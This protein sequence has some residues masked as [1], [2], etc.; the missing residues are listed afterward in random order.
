A[1]KIAGA[2]LVAGRGTMFG[3]MALFAMLFYAVTRRLGAPRPPAP[4]V[5]PPV[6]TGIWPCWPH[7]YHDFLGPGGALGAPLPGPGP[8][9]TRARDW[10]WCGAL[11]ALATWTTLSQGVTAALTLPIAA[12]MI[13]VEERRGVRALLS[14]YLIGFVA[15]SALIM[16]ALAAAGAL[17]PALA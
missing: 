17:R 2:G 4:G 1:F 14:R 13:D 10:L 3:V 16:I 7:A 5:G 6:P 12:V 11:V 8:G 15:A 9:E